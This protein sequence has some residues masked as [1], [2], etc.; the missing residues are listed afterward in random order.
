MDRGSVIDRVRS[1]FCVS[2]QFTRAIGD[3]SIHRTCM[4]QAFPSS[5]FRRTGK[6]SG[7]MLSLSRKPYNP[8]LFF[9]YVS[10]FCNDSCITNVIQA[11]QSLEIP[12]SVVDDFLLGQYMLFA[13]HLDLLHGDWLLSAHHTH[14]GKA[15][16]SLGLKSHSR[17]VC[18]L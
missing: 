8:L 3:S 4:F 10:E 16:A 15:D 7:L 12:H 13:Y 9:L 17:I 1:W 6:A 18:P 14:F 2:W 11:M 5:A